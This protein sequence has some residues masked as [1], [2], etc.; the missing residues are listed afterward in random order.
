MTTSTAGPGRHLAHDAF[1]ALHLGLL[2]RIL[3][4][5]ALVILF[6]CGVGL[7]LGFALTKVIDTAVAIVAG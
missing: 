6:A 4:T 5:S 2:F 3:Y 1:H 7:V